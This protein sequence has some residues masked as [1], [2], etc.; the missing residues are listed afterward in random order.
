METLEAIHTRRSV[1]KY[2]DEPV[3]ER[4]IHTLLE[5]AM[6]APSAGN[7]QPWHFLV[8]TDKELLATV[9]TLSPYMGMAGQAPLA[10]LVCGDTSLEK[11]PGFWVQDCSAALQNLMLAARDLGLGSVW[12]GIYPVEERILSFKRTFSLPETII[13]LGLVVL[14]HTEA[15]GKRESRFKAERAHRNSW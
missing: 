1:R 15:P 3:S 14:G 13:P 6:T 2:R 12:T 5:A 10:V 7:A 8:L 9:S 4:D 11:Y